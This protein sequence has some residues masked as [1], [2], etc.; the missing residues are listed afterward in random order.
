MARYIASKPPKPININQ[1]MG[2][3]EAV[4]QTG[5][6][7]GE[8]LRQVNYKITK[9]F[10]LQKREGHKTFINFGNTKDVQGT[11]EGTIGGQ[12]S[13][14][15]INNGKVYKYNL[16][17]NTDKI[18]IIDL[19]T[20]GTV[21]E[22]GTITDAKTSIF[23][24]ESKL[25]FMNG[26]DYKQY[27]GTTFQN[28]VPHVPLIAE[29]TPPSGGGTDAEP[30]NLLTGEKKQEFI[31]NGT[32]TSYFI[33]EQ[34][35]TSF[36][37]ITVDGVVTVPT[38]TDLTLGKFTFTPALVSGKVVLA[39]WTKVDATHANLVKK[40]RFAMKFGVGNDTSVFI[41][42]H[43]DF[44]NTRRWCG[45]L[46]AGYFP[47]FNLTNVGTND[48]AITDIKT[49]NA[50]YQ[51]IFKEGESHFSYAE[52]ISATG[53]WDYPVKSLNPVV[54]NTVYNGAQIVNNNPIT[55]HGKSW[56]QWLTTSVKDERNTEVIS[57]RLRNSL[58]EIDLSTAVTFDYQNEKEY[59][60]N[61]GDIVYV[62][63]YGNN[64][65]YTFNNISGTCYLD[66]DGVVYYGSQGTVERMKGLDDNGVAIVAQLDTGFNTFGAMQLIK[67]SDMIYVGLLPASQ[68]SITIYFKTNKI[69]EFKRL[70]KKP[71]Y[72]LL[73]FSNIN[74]NLFSFKTNRNPQTFA[75]PINSRD[76]TTIQF[77]LE[78]AELNETCVLL[79]FLVNAETQGEI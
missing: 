75:L 48:S 76:Y 14:I 8:A 66:I 59:W 24:F 72:R 42:G 61:V 69:N 29:A 5:L 28:V 43:P 41:W 12:H 26:T 20:E 54:G 9:D 17:I 2:I 78:N 35:I 3:N 73:D 18:A 16:A 23:Y 79:D 45:T 44:K 56:W 68:T 11:W 65:M 60:C 34:S 46:N 36:G 55:I 10:K 22:I 62:W 30:I 64:T 52:Y 21:F 70:T 50:N 58:S 6:E 25:Y 49:N 15:A 47:V 19:I 37:S 13:F 63:N 1:F 40:N 77:R 53:T 67:T 27:D 32:D 33:R 39:V 57:E 51:I 7:L 31:A 74:F 38:S 4:G 71:Q